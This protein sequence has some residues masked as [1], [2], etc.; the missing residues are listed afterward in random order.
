MRVRKRADMVFL[1]ERLATASSDAQAFNLEEAIAA[2]IQRIVG[3]RLLES[4]NGEV[5][6]LEFGMP[7]I[8]DV[9]YN[10]K[11]AMERYAARLKRLIAHYEPRLLHPKVSVEPTSNTLSP[12]RLVV[13][14]MLALGGDTRTF[15]FDLPEH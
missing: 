15:L 14:G 12:F 6:L 13:S 7:N 9:A 11:T 4:D 5:S 8:V 10:S 2:Q 1:L 3:A